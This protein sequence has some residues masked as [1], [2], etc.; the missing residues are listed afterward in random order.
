MEALY[1]IRIPRKL[2]DRNSPAADSSDVDEK[3]AWLLICRYL[4]QIATQHIS[5]HSIPEFSIDKIK[6]L[7]SIAKNT[8]K[9]LLFIYDEINF[10]INVVSLRNSSIEAEFMGVISSSN[11]LYIKISNSSCSGFGIN[12]LS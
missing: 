3:A 1:Y 6:G 4:P 2:E 8:F 5:M 12:I 9:A 7:T 11:N 10:P